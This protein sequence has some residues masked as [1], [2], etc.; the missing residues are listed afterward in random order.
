MRSCSN[1]DVALVVAC[2]LLVTVRAATT[3]TRSKASARICSAAGSAQSQA[4]AAAWCSRKPNQWWRSRIVCCSTRL[5]AEAH[6]QQPRARRRDGGAHRAPVRPDWQIAIAFRP[7]L[8]LA[9][10]CGDSRR[11]LSLSLCTFSKH[12][13]QQQQQQRT[14]SH[15]LTMRYSDNEDEDEEYVVD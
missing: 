15:S 10:Q 14:Q 1:A 2:C 6:V 4:S 3:R 7:L 5:R 9:L 13:S 8:R 11:S 12:G